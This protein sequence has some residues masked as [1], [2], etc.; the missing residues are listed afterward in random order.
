MPKKTLSKT[1]LTKMKKTEL[2]QIGKEMK[3]KGLSSLRKADII[4]RIIENQKTKTSDSQV[5]TEKI[6]KSIEEKKIIPTSSDGNKGDKVK[7]VIPEEEYHIPNEYHTTR[8]VLMVKDPEWIYT[9]WE[10]SPS[11]RAELQIDYDQMVLR[12]YDVTG[13]N[14]DGNNAHKYFDISPDGIAT[15]WYIHVP[16]PERDYCV[17]LG[18]YDSER[19]FC[20]IARSNIVSVPRNGVSDAFDEEWMSIEELYQLSGGGNR[21]LSG[22]LEIDQMLTERLKLA[23]SSE[24]LVSSWMPSSHEF[25]T[26]K[27]SG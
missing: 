3:L 23:L 9:Y 26:E 7:K 15:N 13:I 14:F 12:V 21:Q 22:S 25:I 19:N 24:S 8:I 10:V 11:K 5:K 20:I 6:I 18:Y 2:L 4:E 17:D 16:L 1:E 27:P